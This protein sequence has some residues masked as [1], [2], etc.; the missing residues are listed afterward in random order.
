MV[1]MWRTL[2][3]ILLTESKI[4]TFVLAFPK[5]SGHR[6]HGLQFYSLRTKLRSPTELSTADLRQSRSKSSRYLVCPLITWTFFAIY[7]IL[8]EKY[9]ETLTEWTSSALHAGQHRHGMHGWMEGSKASNRAGKYI[10]VGIHWYCS[11]LYLVRHALL[12]LISVDTRCWRG[13]R[14]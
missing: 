8:A 2:R 6:Y 1:E 5:A 7:R 3:V 10:E 9:K 4:D 12:F 14:N 11:F 13:M